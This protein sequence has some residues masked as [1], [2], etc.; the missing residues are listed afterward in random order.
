MGHTPSTKRF[1][2]NGEGK[3]YVEHKL[4]AQNTVRRWPTKEELADLAKAKEAPAE[5]VPVAFTAEGEVKVT[6]GAT[7]DIPKNQP[8]SDPVNTEIEA[9]E[10]N[11]KKQVGGR[12]EAQPVA[13]KSKKSRSTGK[14]TAP[15]AE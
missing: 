7:V 14:K 15:A 8:T 13:R 10:E 3:L 1:L 4:D 5:E 9:D 2:R 6:A 11:V 12:K